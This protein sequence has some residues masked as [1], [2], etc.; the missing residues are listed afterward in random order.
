MARR[1]FSTVSADAAVIGPNGAYA[2]MMEASP[3]FVTRANSRGLHRCP[4]NQVKSSKLPGAIK[5]RSTSQP[6]PPGQASKLLAK[7]VGPPGF[8]PV[9]PN[10]GRE[11]GGDTRVPV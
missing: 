5:G 11:R 2:S 1:T 10:E 4:S 3:T 9:F 6:G 8:A 7:L